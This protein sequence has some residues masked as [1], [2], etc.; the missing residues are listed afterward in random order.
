M[1][2]VKESLM[3]HQLTSARVSFRLNA[4]YLTVHDHFL[5]C[6]PSLRALFT[7]HMQFAIGHVHDLL[8]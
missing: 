4:P 5:L 6:R 3:L 2:R 8:G 7:C 1:L